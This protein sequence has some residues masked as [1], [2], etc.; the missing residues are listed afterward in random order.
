MAKVPE[1]PV[2]HHDFYKT[3]G[4]D[5]RHFNVGPSLTR[6]EFAEE[7]DI[8]VIMARYEKTGMLPANNVEPQYVDFTQM[9]GNLMDTM[10]FFDEAQASFMQLPATVR[11]EFDND[12]AAFVD[13]AADPANLDQMRAWGL[14]PKP[15]EPAVAAPPAGSEPP[16]SPAAPATPGLPTASPSPV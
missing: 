16:V 1:F 11:R 10:R 8:N 15:A 12:A 3:N 5:A 9:P 4:V 2:S 7:C 14:A 6:Q 13:Y